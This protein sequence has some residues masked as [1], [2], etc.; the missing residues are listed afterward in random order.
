M[1]AAVRFL[2]SLG[3]SNPFGL[4]FFSVIITFLVAWIFTQRFIPALRSFAVRVG[5]A[6]LPNERRLNKLPLPNVGGL[7]IF[8]GFIGSVVIAWALRPIVIE[9]V[10]IQVLAILLGGA[11]LVL[12]GF[13]D[14]QFGLPP[15]T[16][17]VVQTLSAA[18]LMVNGLSI[19]LASFSWFVG[20]PPWLLGALDIATTWLWVVGITNAFN[21]MDGVDGVAGG[22]GFIASMVLLAVSAQFASRAAATILLAG[23]AGA[24]LGFLR[25]N[26]NPSRIIMGDA[27]AYLFGYTL[28]A[29]ALLGTLKL[30]AGASLVAPVLFLGLPIADTTQVVIGRLRRGVNP[31]SH[32]DKTHLHHRLLGP[33]GARRTAVVLWVVALLF[34]MIGMWAQGI[35]LRVIAAISLAVVF[36]LSWV[37]FRRLM[38]LRRETEQAEA[39]TP[40]P[41][42]S[43]KP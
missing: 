3:I 37:A 13:I 26:F 10:Q 21:L 6:D 43:G 32:P 18:V 33:L 35:S 12:V 40:L 41:S 11:L 23:L 27:G 19:D 7:A 31:L 20:W 38:A 39:D 25:H 8:A 36:F 14:D 16:R 29:V 24:A 34:N 4:G 30:A 17:L 5:W 28:A 22:I 2:H 42:G 1:A 15:W 9:R